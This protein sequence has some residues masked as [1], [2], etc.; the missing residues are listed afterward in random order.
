MQFYAIIR[1]FIFFF[2]LYAAVGRTQ[3]V[4]EL[5]RQI[6][7]YVNDTLFTP[8]DAWYDSLN[9]DAKN[10]KICYTIIG[11]SSTK[12]MVL[13]K[14]QIPQIVSLKQVLRQI[15][16]YYSLISREKDR[17]KEKVNIYAYFQS[18]RSAPM[19]KVA[20]QSP[21]VFYIQLRKWERIPA[22]SSPTP[23]EK[24]IFN[25][26]LQMAF[27]EVQ[28]FSSISE[29]VFKKVALRNSMS[30]EVVKKIYQNITLWQQAQSVGCLPKQE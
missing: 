8:S 28:T 6:V 27:E 24:A 21:G 9:L 12:S 19:L 16:L 5:P 15:V 1:Y 10:S 29:S 23:E 22:P 2:L 13:T 25:Q 26:V 18:I 11:T 14:I 4:I 3:P 7:I 30:V 17:T 20:Y